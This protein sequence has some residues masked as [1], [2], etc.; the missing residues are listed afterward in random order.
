MVRNFVAP[1]WIASAAA[2]HNIE[3]L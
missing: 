2:H 3:A 1:G